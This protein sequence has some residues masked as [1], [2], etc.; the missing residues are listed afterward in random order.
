MSDAQFWSI[1]ALVT[2]ITL[3]GWKVDDTL[4]QILETLKSK[5]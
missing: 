5:Q 4:K 1:W 2:T 3:I